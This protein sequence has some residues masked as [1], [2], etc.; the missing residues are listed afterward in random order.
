M[1]DAA[2][3]AAIAGPNKLGANLPI[4]P[5]GLVRGG[6]QVAPGVPKNLSKPQAG[7]DSKLW[8]GAL[9]PRQSQKNGDTRVTV[10]QTKS[11]AVLNWETL[12]VGKKTTLFFDQSKGGNDKTQWTAFNKITD[13]SGKPSQILGK[14][15]GEGQVYVINPNGILF[16]G[17]SQINLHGLVASSLPINDGLITRGLLNNPDSQ[18]LFSALPFAT[19]KNGTPAFTPAPSNAPGGKYGDVVVQEGA[20][21][22]SPSSSGV[23]GRIM[24][25]GPNVANGGTI[26]TPDGQTVL[27][28]GLQ[29]GFTAHP[30]NDARLRGLDVYVGAVTVPPPA[31]PEDPPVIPAQSPAGLA[32]NTGLIDAPRANTTI[33]GKD[34][35]QMGVIDSAT[36][37]SLNGSINLLANFGTVTVTPES[38]PPFFATT[39]SGTVTIGPDAVNQ[40]LPDVFNT[41]TVIG[42]QLSLRSKVTVEGRNIH[43]GAN[44]TLLAPNADVIFRAGEWLPDGTGQRLVF[45]TGQIYVD[46]GALL[47]VAGTTDVVVPIAQNILSLELRGAELA[48]AP[49][50]RGGPLRGPTLNLD[51]RQRGTFGGR[52]W[53]GTPLGEVSGYANLIERNVFELTTAG[54]TI[55]MTAGD[56]VIVRSGAKIDVSGGFVNFEGGTV[57]TTRVMS[58]SRVMDIANATPDRPFTGLYDGT[59]TF[60]RPKYGITEKWT[61]PLA[62]SGEHFEPGYV[63]GKS[64][65]SISITAPSMAL[66]GELKGQTVSG[67]RQRTAQA[68]PK[69]SA[70]SL[71]FEKQDGKLSNF[72]SFS[73]TP[74]AI[75]FGNGA[76][77]DPGDYSEDAA[78][79]AAPLSA[80]RLARV[81]LS[82][83]LFTSS[84]FGSLTINNPDGDAS[85]PEETKLKIPARGAL[86]ITGADVDIQGTV[87]APSGNLSFT[88]Y[89]QT[90]F[91]DQKF[92]PGSTKT[93]PAP[94]L[95]RGTV[96]LGANAALSVAGLVIDDRPLS[97][98]AL[99]LPIATDGGSVAI[100]GYNAELIAGSRIDASGG[101]VFDRAGRRSYGAGGSIS[102]KAGND[103]KL[104]QLIGG[105]LRLESTLSAFSG[106]KG[107]ALAIQAPSIQIGGAKGATEFTLLLQPEFFSSGGFTNFA[108]TGLGEKIAGEELEFITA[109]DIAPGTTIK[110]IAKNWNAIPYGPGL[111]GAELTPVILEQSLRTPVSLSF[112]APG[113]RDDFNGNSL[114]TR[115]DIAVGADVLIETDPRASISFSGETVSIQG[116][117][118]A[119]GGSISVGGSRN[120]GVA[121]GDSSASLTS[122]HIGPAALLSTKGT[123]LYTP[124]PYGFRTGSVLPGGR[125]SLSGN[126]VA[127]SGA[128]LDVS[129]ASGVIETPVPFAELNGNVT[130]V[131]V[132][133]LN[134]GV[135][136]GLYTRDYVSTRIDSDAGDINIAGG[137][138]LFMDATLRGNA[139]GPTALGGNLTVSSDI[140]LPVG[141]LRQPT[142][143][144]LHVTQSGPTLPP[145]FVKIN[146]AA[147]GLGVHGVAGRG[148][149]AADTFSRGGFDSLTLRGTVEFSGP[150]SIEARRNL[151]VADAGVLFA[152]SDVTLKAPYVILGQ[153][154]L[155]P[156]AFGAQSRNPYLDSGGQPVKVKPTH[157]EGRLTVIGDLIDI[158]NLSLQNIDTARFIADN[159]DIRGNGTLEAAGHIFMRAAQVY[160]PSAITFS[161]IAT[162]YKNGEETISG[163]VTFEASGV[164]AL[165]LSAGG[166]L[167]VFATNITQNGTL[168]VPLGTINLGW[169]GE[170]DAPVSALSGDKVSATKTVTLGAGSFTSVSAI[171]PVEG[172]DLIVPFG[173]NINGVTWI[174]PTGLDI[175]GGGLSQKSINIAGAN[176]NSMAGSRLDIRGGGD[177]LSYRWVSGIGGSRDLL[178]STT[179]FAILPGYGAHFSPYSANSG[180]AALSG[181]PG[182]V[183]TALRVGDCIHLGAGAGLEEGNYTLLP[184]RY[185]LLPGARLV[186]LKGG[187]PIGTLDLP[188]GSTLVPG[189]RFNGLN[190][191]RTLNPQLSWYEVLTPDAISDRAQ[192][193]SYFG[194]GFLKSGAQQL[195]SKVPRLPGDAGQLTLQ[196]TSSMVLNGRVSA[197]APKGSR[198]GLVDIAS[199]TD[200]VITGDGRNAGAGK[201]SLSASQLSAFGA[202]SLLIGGI[203]KVGPDSTTV[204]VKTGNV[205]LDNAGT[206]LSGPEIILV[207]NKSL[208]LA[209]GAEILQQGKMGAGGDTLVLGNSTI[210]GSGDSTLL[211]VTS[212]PS[213][214]IIR[215]GLGNSTEP[216]MTIGAGA[217]IAGTSVTLDSTYGTSLDPSARIDASVIALNSGQISIQL[218]NSGTLNPTDGLV[219]GGTALA[220]L[221]KSNSVSLLSYS[222]L[223]I[224]GTGTFG[225]AGK[226]ALHAGEIRGYNNDGGN[227]TISAGALSLDNST[228]AIIPAA[229]GAMSGTLSLNA[230][231]ITLGKGSLAIDQFETVRLN[232]SNGIIASGKGGLSAQGSIIANA[233]VI[234]AARS[235][236]HG[237]TAGGDLRLEANGSGSIAGGLG[238]TLAFQGTSVFASTNINLPSGSL[239]IRA[240]TG[241]VNIE[242]R[243]NLNGTEQSFYDLTRYTSG[244][245]VRLRSDNGSVLIN[246]GSVI[247]VSAS[248]GADAGS[249]T[250]SAPKGSFTNAGE[251]TGKAVAGGRGGSFTLDAGTLPSFSELETALTTGGFSESQNLRIRTGDVVID[252]LVKANSFRLSTDVGSITVS[253]TI[254]ASGKF[255]GHIALIGGGSVIVSGALNAS[256]QDFNAAGKGGS[257]LIETRGLNSGVVNLQAGSSVDLGVASADATSAAFGRFTGTLHLRAPQN[258]AASD[259]GVATIGG[260]I[261]GASSIIVEGYRVFTPTAGN[262]TTGTQTQVLNNGRTFV[263]VDG[264]PSATYAAM[265]ARVLGTNTA[266][267]PVLS[268]RPGAEIVNNTGNVTLG[269]ATSTYANDWNLATYRFGAK[270]APGVLTIRAFGN[271]TLFNTISDGFQTAAWNSLLLAQNASLPVNSQSWS[272]RFT[273]GVDTT[274]ADFAQVREIG[275]IIADSGSVLLGKNGGDGIYLAPGTNVATAAAIA[276]SNAYQVLRTGSGDIT[277]HAGR[278]VQLRNQFA[279]IFTA[280][281]Q[282]ANPGTLPNGGAFDIPVPSVSGPQGSAVG[283]SLGVDGRLTTYPAQFTVAGGNIAIF[284]QNDIA[285]TTIINGQTVQDS[286]RQMPT[287]WLYRRGYVDSVTGEFATGLVSTSVDSTAW[288]VDFSNFFEGVGALGGGNV[289]LKADRDIANV[290]AVIPTNARMPKGKPDLANLVE[291][292]GGNLEVRAGRNIDGGAY[293]VE[294][295][296]GLLSAGA[297]IKT[298]GTRSPSLG[299]DPE[300]S[301]LPTTLFLG[302]G[303]YDITARGNVL[304]GPVAN[305]F[306]L[307]S[308]YYNAVRYKSYFSTFSPDSAVSVASL[309]GDV[310]FRLETVAISDQVAEPEPI[311]LTWYREHMQFGQ[312]SAA[313]TTGNYQPWLLLN[314]TDTA[315]FRTAFNLMPSTLRATSFSGSVNVTGKMT[316]SPSPTGTVELAA[317]KAVNGFTIAG[318]NTIEGTPTNIWVTGSVVLS[319]ASPS[320]ISGAA[321]PLG[322]LS[323]VQPGGNPVST[324]TA[325]YD[326]FNAL[327]AENGA[328]TNALDIKQS[329]HAPGLLHA[330]DSEPLRIYAGTG[331]VQGLNI[332]SPKAANIYAGRDISDIGIYIQNLSDEDVSVVAAGR[333]I[334]AYN[335][336]T[337]SRVQAASPGNALPGGSAPLAGDLQVSGPGTLEVLAGRN[338]DLGIGKSNADRTGL[339]L[340]SVGNARNPSLPFEGA[341]LVVGAG[342]GPATGLGTGELDFKTFVAEILAGPAAVRYEAELA[343][344]IGGDGGSA[345]FE[346]L[347]EKKQHLAALQVFFLMLRDAGR[348]HNDPASPDFGT[349]AGG[350]KAIDTLFPGTSWKGDI[351]LTSRQIKTAAGGDISMFAPGGKIIVGFDAGAGQSLDQG[352]LTE[353]G[354]NI[355]M[356]AHESVTLGTSRIFTL[357][358]GNEMIWSSTGDIAAGTSSKTVASAPPTRVSID[359]QSADLKNDLAGLA[360]GGGIG[361]LATVEGLMPGDVDLIAPGGA[362]DAGDA[363]I[364]SAGNLNVAA[365]TLLNS[366]NIA[367]TG[368]AAGAPAG[369][370]PAP[371]APPAPPPPPPPD[372]R[373]TADS[374]QK[375]RDEEEKKRKTVQQQDP[376]SIFSVEVLGYGGGEGPAAR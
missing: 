207:A 230:G 22:S 191:E 78:G 347:P 42:T 302:K 171:S 327:F 263:G 110:P 107:G 131:S 372:N 334:I 276:Q 199:S 306:L 226:L 234:T 120:L 197:G 235:A 261:T 296:D 26:S 328:L 160:P 275:S 326:T 170:G 73:P 369:P 213:A 333:D 32:T 317:S 198:G 135:N 208:T 243:V 241:D 47:S 142:D 127:E 259:L 301:W 319:D 20:Q 225:I 341:D 34:V 156:L 221:E 180:A 134:S 245:E 289:T 89:N 320:A 159:G 88:A 316:L 217:H 115:G 169:N 126:I 77:S 244:G 375:S 10:Q 253:G 99:S 5:N 300:Q 49:L 161:I 7:E 74:P 251:F 229:T 239:S 218:D 279:S 376:A 141:A 266:L 81:I 215:N 343:E 307:P 55:S 140:F 272:Y 172:Q 64:G 2:R 249:L 3:A 101:V 232:A 66:D 308:G 136:T 37:V 80:E 175:T 123:T 209:D 48:D 330:A 335:A 164:R 349:Y 130:G 68:A 86:A 348:D 216:R 178:A 84:G 18:F 177:L 350:F 185:A 54:G 371:P 95:T 4:I 125:I 360:T 176:V 181:D 195:E 193:A 271:I 98:S 363:G 30:S 151:S 19:G 336:N 72:A 340:V 262:I 6:L 51:I 111:D 113:L 277:I 269:S 255:G 354:G 304:L 298:N 337:A 370:P 9:L 273:S 28:A 364:R 292:G 147:I 137:Q 294:R 129:G 67:P 52:D 325:F 254:D 242:G 287:N 71:S 1:Q 143:V 114:V 44:S 201:L 324:G 139:G 321:S 132:V 103:P 278:D 15:E 92:P 150:V 154:F 285:H 339:G 90:P 69:L 293:Y 252:G 12:N 238:A 62:L 29:V 124:N 192:Y 119:P 16:G 38:T 312:S 318:R 46:A 356:F 57:Q 118:I 102:I 165:P 353:S 104:L 332:F 112:A 133:P 144:T 21:L 365:T 122:V 374:S 256:G 79:N 210:A 166:T 41:K 367:V 288:W 189:Y 205:T 223:D 163:S 220:S 184:A 280:G 109:I 76:L 206:P 105:R 128:V 53:I 121:F 282:V 106:G 87:T 93:L 265:L 352:I 186:S 91:L 224:Y 311:L 58:D 231:T 97:L 61:H 290:D 338:L 116:R 268:I 96:T 314:E 355:H 117:I 33:A 94:D 299:V 187:T 43:L 342:I 305:P 196:A 373:S 153:P 200:I 248:G 240:T 45:S 31:K 56:S 233:P 212:D 237:I 157:G 145:G 357:R 36:S 366:E 331:D 100:A 173:L 59:S 315:P 24:L 236:V 146:G 202:E 138:H 14:I 148:Y 35:R 204:T 23:G 155:A 50:Q 108:L 329:L 83:D 295:G 351:S 149:F 323:T 167:N 182:F 11:Q 310:S 85:I 17:S 219:L 174:D 27:A 228:G 13:P 246:A 179:S 258:T 70:L 264:T 257:V 346:S 194:N 362:I 344:I 168:R 286:T 284:A 303:S 283:N 183:N 322:F 358:G 211:R 274:A 361:V 190:E 40:I 250:I 313:F 39:A 309:G 281:T 297:E 158:G 63:E 8:T 222:T 60:N 359:P 345:D 368:T 260:A 227:V 25:V 188:D 270:H 82:P 162:D 214:N 65:G 291:F 247:S 75:T 152:D 203:R 267:D